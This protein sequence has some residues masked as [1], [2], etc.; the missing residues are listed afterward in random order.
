M[1]GQ[2]FLNFEF[3]SL[4]TGTATA[5][6]LASDAEQAGFVSQIQL[7]STVGIPSGKHTKNYGKSL[8]LM[9]KS[10]ISVAMFNSFV[11]LPE[12]LHHK[13]KLLKLQT[14]LPILWAHIATCLACAHLKI[15]G[16]HWNCGPNSP[17]L[18]WERVNVYPFN[19]VSLII[20]HHPS[21]I[22]GRLKLRCLRPRH[23]PQASASGATME[24]G[25]PPVLILDWEF[26]WNKLSSYWGTPMTTETHQKNTNY[27]RWL[28]GNAK[29]PR[30]SDW[31]MMVN[32]GNPEEICWEI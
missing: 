22:S 13:T 16:F 3:A 2:W 29:W 5:S 28:G 9:G 21:V 17:I 1:P 8:F 18:F 10:I 26:P 31:W 11:K 25:V 30:I 15:A 24:I 4:A 14:N 7:I 6:F 19:S 27:E 32:A 20:L 12:G 23:R